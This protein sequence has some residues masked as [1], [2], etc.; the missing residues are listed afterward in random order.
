MTGPRHLPG[1][2]QGDPWSQKAI[3]AERSADVAR[4]RLA[5]S[6]PETRRVLLSRYR[7]PSS[8]PLTGTAW[9]AGSVE[10]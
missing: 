4:V 5:L 8:T 6:T 2:T 10:P 1:S 7:Q 9:I 3:E